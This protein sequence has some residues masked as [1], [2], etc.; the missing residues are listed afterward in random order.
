MSRLQSQ[1]SHALDKRITYVLRSRTQYFFSAFD[2]ERSLPAAFRGR[3]VSLLQ[4]A[5]SALLRFAV[6][7]RSNNTGRIMGSLDPIWD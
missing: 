2:I 6:A 7:R 3:A 4:S 1:A 5:L